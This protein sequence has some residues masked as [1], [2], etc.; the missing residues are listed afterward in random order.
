MFLRGDAS[1]DEAVSLPDEAFR[2]M[3]S[4]SG[5]GLENGGYWF[6]LSLKNNEINSE[7][8]VLQIATHNLNKVTIYR[9]GAQSLTYVTDSKQLANTSAYYVDSRFITFSLPK[10]PGDTTGYYLQTH[11]DKEAN[12]PLRIYGE[13]EYFSYSMRQT[14]FAGWYYGLLSAVVIFN[15]FFFFKFRDPI[16][17]FYTIFLV[18]YSC[19][20]FYY[21][22]LMGMLNLSNLPVDLEAVI[23]LTI[24][25]TMFLFSFRFLNLNH[26][27]PA[28]R[29]YAIGLVGLMAMFEV[30]Y[31]TTGDFLFFA[32]A[33]VIAMCSFLIT[34]LIGL[35]LIRQLKFARFYVLGYFILIVC[36]YYYVIAYNFGIFYIDGQSNFLKIASAFDI[37]IFT[38]AITYR[39]DVLN[40]EHRH[41]IKELRT[42]LSQNEEKQNSDP[43]YS[44]LTENEI[45][46][47]ALT[48]REIEVL[49]CLGENMTNSE[50]AEKL[51]I[52]N[53]TV[54]F[55]VRNIYQKLNIKNRKEVNQKI[56]GLT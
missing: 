33:D 38:Y 29:K 49:K 34:W 11:F 9:R 43:L 12:F 46:G 22:G 42:M 6:K 56:A 10:H 3:P 13:K 45:T 36:G 8:F 4:S 30:I 14:T 25:I 40:K 19:A 7:R 44:L 21:D 55:H 15:L 37:L 1:P 52:S 17:L 39:M 51:F 28:F 48:I 2:K 18:S 5:F 23:H 50:I 24:E 47:Q 53:N 32:M 35:S 31:L 54:K 26:H 20:M 41:M 16:Y 27:L